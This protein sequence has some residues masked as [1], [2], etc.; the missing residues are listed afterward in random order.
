MIE[1]NDITLQLCTIFNQ[2]RRK[3]PTFYLKQMMI[4]E[5][6]EDTNGIIRIRKSQ[7]SKEKV[8]RTNND[9]QN[10]HKKLKIAIFYSIKIKKIHILPRLYNFIIFLLL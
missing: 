5:E 4:E 3:L 9:L 8:Q 1:I 10:I 7:W 6:F 2:I